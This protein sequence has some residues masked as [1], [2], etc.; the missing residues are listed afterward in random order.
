MMT[1]SMKTSAA[2]G[3]MLLVC[4]VA[5]AWVRAQG[6][7]VKTT[8]IPDAARAFRLAKAAAR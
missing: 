5:I 8:G 3:V 4:A 2:S 7:P 1:R 6:V